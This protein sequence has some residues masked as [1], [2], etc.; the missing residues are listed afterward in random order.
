MT[1][2][3][4]AATS[5]TRVSSTS[6][7]ATTPAGTAGA[8]S[9]VVTNTDLQ[10]GTLAGGYTYVAAP[11]AWSMNPTGGPSAGGTAV[12][13]QGT[14]FLAGAVVTFGW[15]S[16][17]VTSLS[18]T[19]ITAIHPSS[20]AGNVTVTVR[21]PDGQSA[22]VPGS[23]S[24][25]NPAGCWPE[26]SKTTSNMVSPCTPAVAGP[27]M[28]GKD[29]PIGIGSPNS[30]TM[31]FPPLWT[32][33]SE[34]SNKLIFFYGAPPVPV[35]ARGSS[36]ATPTTSRAAGAAADGCYRYKSGDRVMVSLFGGMSSS[37]AGGVSRNATAGP[38]ITTTTYRG[39]TPLGTSQVQYVSSR[40]NGVFDRMKK[41]GGAEFDLPLIT[42]DTNGDG[43][44]D[45]MSLPWAPFAAAVLRDNFLGNGDTPGPT[46]Q[47]WLPLADT[48]GDGYG[49]AVV[50]DPAGTGSP[51]PVFPKTPPLLPNV[52]ERTG[53]LIPTLGEWG[54]FALALSLAAAGWLALRRSVA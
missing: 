38:T 47:I 13:I 50:F 49:D 20:A 19:S 54:L 5:V 26:P 42:M 28:S 36:P 53:L 23:F 11:T 18:S 14:G 37:A 30:T 9:V 12:T 2:G 17:T 15:L 29:R 16:A 41:I 32:G 10:S 24:S 43:Y 27:P 4:T 3:G 39:T 7:T 21:N 51:S 31:V 46:P 40:G 22:S 35:S 44:A 48:D 1:I 8:R 6:I 33:S 45:Y 52:A 34:S 25:F